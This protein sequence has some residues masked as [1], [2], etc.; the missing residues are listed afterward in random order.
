MHYSEKESVTLEFKEV[1]PKNNQVVK[2][3][4]GFCNYKGGKLVIG[5]RDDGTIVGLNDKQVSHILKHLDKKIFKSTS[6]AIIPNIYTQTLGDKI[7]VI[8]EVS[9]G[10]NKP[11]FLTQE[12]VQKGTYIRLGRTTMRA[13]SDVIKEL[14]WAAQGRSYDMMP[15]YYA[16]VD[17]LDRDKI[18][19][20]LESRKGSGDQPVSVEEALKAYSLVAQ[21]NGRIYPTIAGILLFGKAPQKFFLEA[22]VICSHFAGVE[23]RETLA[24]RDCLG[25]IFEQ[26]KRAENF[27]LSN[28]NRSFTINGLKRDEKYEV[29]EKAIREA[30]VNALV[31]RNYHIKAPIKVAIYDNRIEIFSPGGFYGLLSEENLLMGFTYTRN[32]TIVKVF[33]EAGYSEKLGT[34]IRIIFSTYKEYGL[35]EPRIYDAGNFVMCVLPRKQ[36]SR[37]AK[38]Q[39][40]P[41]LLLILDLFETASELSRREIVNRL[42]IP[43]TTVGRK[44]S[45]LVKEGLLERRGFS[46]ATRYIRTKRKA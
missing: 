7:L 4:I 27:I 15:V 3:V 12:G 28:I 37:M 8:V 23:G 26:L 33:R 21:E 19:Q 36:A 44:L 10:M 34:G 29:P 13:T 22:F 9:S 14:S 38:N 40:D 24:T 32:G 30:L 39:K 46:S 16:G 45:K 18:Q 5:V 43:A 41:Q 11:Y 35:K 20:F 42:N 6:P 1:L 25:T 2:T 31:H 17:E